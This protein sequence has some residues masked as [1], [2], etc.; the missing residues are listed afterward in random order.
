MIFLFHIAV[1]ISLFLLSAPATALVPP[2][3]LYFTTD[4]LYEIASD[5]ENKKKGELR[6][7]FAKAN[8]HV[9]EFD[10]LRQRDEITLAFGA[11]VE[12]QEAH[13][14]L[15][16]EKHA[17][18]RMS[19]GVRVEGTLEDLVRADPNI[20]SAGGFKEGKRIVLRIDYAW[21]ESA[22]PHVSRPDPPP[23]KPAKQPPKSPDPKPA[24]AKTK[25]PPKSKKPREPAPTSKS[26]YFVPAKTLAPPPFANWRKR[27]RSPPRSSA[28]LALVASSAR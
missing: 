26:R 28:S 19:M 15:L 6:S 16:G 24:V 3:E 23:T 8:P 14:R 5:S 4:L 11:V 10:I 20:E 25:Q 21:P 18:Y 22:L 17:Y 7:S 2:L 1:S 27:C 9:P 12:G 13:F